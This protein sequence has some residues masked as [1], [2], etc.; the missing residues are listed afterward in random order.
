M[1]CNIWA[2]G[3]T[4]SYENLVKATIFLPS[5]TYPYLHN[6]H[7]PGNF[8][9]LDETQN[10]YTH[11]PGPVPTTLQ[12]PEESRIS[13]LATVPARRPGERPVCHTPCGGGLRFRG[14][15]GQPL[16][17]LLQPASYLFC[18]AASE[19]PSAHELRPQVPKTFSP[20]D[21]AR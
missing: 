5:K 9:G 12:M 21:P 7:F 10:H 17:Y 2:V 1:I 11:R 6:Q 14:G 16:S 20:A 19:Q 4:D 3:C 8:R 13:C 15:Q 18:R